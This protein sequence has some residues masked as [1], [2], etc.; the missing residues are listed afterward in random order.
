MVICVL[1]W[2]LSALALFEA[3]NFFLVAS[4]WYVSWSLRTRPIHWAPL[5]L[6]LCGDI[7]LVIV[8]LIGKRWDGIIVSDKLATCLKNE[9]DFKED[10]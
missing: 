5:S 10:C 7:L 8:V 3:K 1:G 6:V 9:A 2:N 4:S